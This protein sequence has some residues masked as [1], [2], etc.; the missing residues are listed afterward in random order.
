[1]EHLEDNMKSL[2][3][4]LIY[5]TNALQKQLVNL[6][7]V[8]MFILSKLIRYGMFLVF[9]FLLMSG[10]KNIGGYSREQMVI[11]YL[12]FNII[13]TTSQLL[14][15]EVY[16]FRPL[17]ISGNFDMVLTKPFNPLIRVLLGGPDFIDAGI[18]IILIGTL[19]FFMRNLAGLNGSAL[20]YF[21]LMILNSLLI[22]AALHIVVLGIGILTLSVDH[23]VM[24]YRD[25][26]SLVR[27]PVDLFTNPLRS[28]ITFVIPVGIMFTFP[29]KSLLGLLSWEM[30]VVSFAIGIGGLFLAF[31]FWKYS[32]TQYQSASS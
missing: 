1:M 23:L 21:C 30:M 22:A 10:V 17:I 28:I 6:P 14:F 15:R 4:I 9:L 16:F 2:R 27:I 11:F 13:D 12:A 3:I 24:I 7:I 29:V 20:F 19:V 31:R 26:T 25:I 5:Y 18:L 32:L 8:T